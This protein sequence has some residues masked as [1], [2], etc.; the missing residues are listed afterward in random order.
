[1]LVDDFEETVW[2]QPVK[3]HTQ[4]MNTATSIRSFFMSPKTP[5]AQI[6]GKPTDHAATFSIK[7]G[8]ADRES[9]GSVAESSILFQTEFQDPE[10]PSFS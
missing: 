5:L 7:P 9:H 4:M 6:R 10:L 3:R 8:L 1:M 2:A